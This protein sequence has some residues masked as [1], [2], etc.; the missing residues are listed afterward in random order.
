[1]TAVFIANWQVKEGQEAAWAEVA[2]E[3]EPI[4]TRLGFQNQRFFTAYG[5][6][7]VNGNLITWAAE[8]EN[9]AALGAVLDNLTTDAEIQGW[10]AK[11]NGSATLVGS[12]IA[13]EVVY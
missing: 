9:L 1:M 6:P 2:K 3:F 10:L 11:A 5:N 8:C 4:G 13:N 12:Q 7:A